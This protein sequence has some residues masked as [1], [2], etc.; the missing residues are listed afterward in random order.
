MQISAKIMLKGSNR[1][2][3]NGETLSREKMCE[4]AGCLSLELIKEG[5][6]HLYT[7]NKMEKKDFEHVKYTLYSPFSLHNIILNTSGSNSFKEVRNLHFVCNN[8]GNKSERVDKHFKC[9]LLFS[10]IHY[11][12]QN[13]FFAIFELS[14]SK[15]MRGSK[16]FSGSKSK[17]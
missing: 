13:T 7:G 1:T 6:L 17:S 11:M 4:H 9:Y 16:Y 8:T 15:Y 3:F 2:I 5:P 10:Q 14:G 12:L